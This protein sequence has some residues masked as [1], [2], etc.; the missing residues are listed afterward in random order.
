MAILYFSMQEEDIIE[1][2]KKKKKDNVDVAIGM[3]YGVASLLNWSKSICN[4]T[5]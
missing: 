2:R 5:L 4:T 3:D 1:K